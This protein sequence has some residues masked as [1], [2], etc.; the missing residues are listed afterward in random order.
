[1]HLSVIYAVALRDV[2]RFYR[3][4]TQLI[5]SLTRSVMWLF[6]M[7]FGLRGSVNIGGDIS[8]THYIFPG[9]IGMT[10]MFAA[11]QQAIS[12]VWDREFGFLKE[13]LV[14]PVSRT[15]IAMGK[16]VSGG[17]ISFTQGCLVAVLGLFLGI[18]FDLVGVLE[19]L[20]L[21][22]LAGVAL[23][24][25]GIVVASRITS[26]QGFGTI[27]NFF[28]MPMFFL[29]GAMYPVTNLPV[30]LYAIV[31]INP[32]SYMVDGMRGSILGEQWANFGLGFDVLFLAGF[33]VLMIIW[34]AFSFRA[35]G[36]R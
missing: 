11:V 31:R 22:A 29:S 8:Y 25:L 9:I 33:F 27:M 21:M 28:L 35:E 1:M 19:M 12:I 4:R 10:V 20:L 14:A 13:I 34:A 30:W 18:T 5:G 7:G 16:A 36:R 2:I 6:I 24:S 15:A 26:F 17:V 3:E 23:S 32:L